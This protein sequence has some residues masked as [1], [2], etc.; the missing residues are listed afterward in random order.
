MVSSPFR[1]ILLLSFRSFKVFNLNISIL[2]AK[3]N[4]K[5]NFLH[6]KGTTHLNSYVKF[7]E[8]EEELNNN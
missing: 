7:T 1:A 5:C 2:K 3:D 6:L 8:F 4:Q